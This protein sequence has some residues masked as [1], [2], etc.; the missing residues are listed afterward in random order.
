MSFKHPLTALFLL[1]GFAAFA[2]ALT[3]GTFEDCYNPNKGYQCRPNEV[4]VTLYD[5]K[6]GSPTYSCIDYLDRR[7]RGRPLHE[8]FEDICKEKGGSEVR[9]SS[10]KNEY[11]CCECY[12]R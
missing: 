3:Y 1:A 2:S 7:N 9:C 8:H 12:L 10:S 5:F 6:R 4:R 11:S